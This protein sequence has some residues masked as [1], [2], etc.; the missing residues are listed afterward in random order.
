[1]NTIQANK[2]LDQVRGGADY[3]EAT[4]TK[5]LFLV[6]EIDEHQYRAMEGGMRS[7]GMDCALQEA[8]TGAWT[9]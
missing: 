7:P 6:G 2:I 9:Q 1:M 3:S 4:I 8:G 5:A